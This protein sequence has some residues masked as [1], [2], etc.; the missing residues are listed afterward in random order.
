MLEIPELGRHYTAESTNIDDPHDFNHHY[1]L[2]SGLTQHLLPFLEACRLLAKA[3]ATFRS[4]CAASWRV[5]VGYDKA[6]SVYL[7]WLDGGDDRLRG[8]ICRSDQHMLLHMV[9]LMIL[10]S[11][12]NSLHCCHALT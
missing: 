12:Y 5:S 8:R 1:M 3:R 7:H 4:G 10:R 6:I 11:S 2:G 9:L